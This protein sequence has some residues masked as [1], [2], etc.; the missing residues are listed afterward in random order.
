MQEDLS[1][2]VKQCPNCKSQAAHLRRDWYAKT[3]PFR[4]LACNSVFGKTLI[5]RCPGCGS[6]DARLRRDWHQ[7]A[8][9]IRCRACNAVY[10]GSDTRAPGKAVVG[11]TPHITRL[12][13]D[14][15]ASRVDRDTLVDRARGLMLGI[16]AGNLLGLPVE[17]WS[18]ERI[19]A[20]YPV[21]IL[22]INP[23]ETSRRV[24]DDAAQAIE[25]AEA[26]LEQTDTVDAFARRLIA[27]KSVNGRGLGR[28]TRQAIAQLADGMRPPH[29]AYSVYR[30]KGGISPNGGIM[31]CAPVAVYYRTRPE[32]LTRMSSETCS[33][34]HYAPL[35]QWSCVIANAVIAML[36]G[37]HKPD[38]Q[39]LLN[40]AKE[41]GCPD[42]LS[43]GRKAGMTTTVLE[44]AAAGRPAPESISWL[45]SNQSVKGHT[46]LTLQAG[47]WA[48]ATD[49]PLEEGLIAVVS[50]G[51]DTDTNGTLAGAVLGARYGASAIPLRWTAYITQRERFAHLGERLL[52]ANTY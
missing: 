6:Q 1:A 33:V 39:R 13:N 32:M 51:G 17:G 41:D 26:L 21:G 43:A 30:A 48:A 24:D 22:D 45:G 12:L 49:L 18:H 47:L 29:A 4:C 16:A 15:I 28:T 2:L 46:I 19:A 9:P 3:N 11:K 25:L 8:R 5:K 36:L 27:W 38:L 7:R 50:S 31:R 14:T 42:L 40:A 52:A 35:A 34:T 20:R 10:G 37:G 23:R 44:R